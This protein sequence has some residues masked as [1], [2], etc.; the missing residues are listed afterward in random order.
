MYGTFS[1]IVGT[2]DYQGK[3]AVTANNGATGII[4][5]DGMIQFVSGDWRTATSIT[6]AV[7]GAT[8]N[9]AGFVS[10][11]Y[12][13]GDKVIWGGYSCNIVT[14]KQIGRAHV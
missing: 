2:F 8:E 5:A 14:G 4:L 13:V 1:G 9:I 12:G 11:S 6:G 7:S 10:P 3:E